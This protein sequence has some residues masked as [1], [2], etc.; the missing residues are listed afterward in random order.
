[1]V[2]HT[3]K[4]GNIIPCS[5]VVASYKP[6]ITV[7][8]QLIKDFAKEKGTSLCISQPTGI[9]S[10]AKE[11]VKQY[12]TKQGLYSWKPGDA[13]TNDMIINQFMRYIKDKTPY[14]SKIEGLVVTDDDRD[15]IGQ[16][17]Q[18]IRSNPEFNHACMSGD[19]ATIDHLI[20]EMIDFEVSQICEPKKD[21]AHPRYNRDR[22][23]LRGGKRKSTRRRKT[24]KR[25]SR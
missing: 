13:L 6:M 11:A 23:M 1:M 25:F 5:S 21:P 2:R 20:D 8:R 15:Y 14:A 3:R 16:V 10:L 9:K 22:T 24:R 7:L 4:G 19:S 17:I 18:D 12:A